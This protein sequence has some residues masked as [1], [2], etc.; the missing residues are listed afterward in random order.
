M[1]L[2]PL[3]ILLIFILLSACGTPERSIKRGDAAMAIGEYCEA[4]AQ[5]K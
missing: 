1:K 5:Y 3:Y 2:S 4:A